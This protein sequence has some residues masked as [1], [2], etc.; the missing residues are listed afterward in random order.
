MVGRIFPSSTSLIKPSQTSFVLCGSLLPSSPNRYHGSAS[1]SR[2]RMARAKPWERGTYITKYCN[3]LEQNSIGPYI[4]NA[5][6]PGCESYHNQSSPILQALDPT[7][8]SPNPIIHN[9]HPLST[10]SR[11][12][13]PVF[14]PLV[15]LV[16]NNIRT[17][18]INHPSFF[19][20]ANDS[21][22]LATNSL[23]NLHSHDT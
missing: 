17:D 7:L 5:P 14:P 21:N 12:P 10:V 20:S 6:I 23:C 8:H 15:S 3:S 9:I 4:F 13:N 2:N 19:R 22:D 16:H 18:P 11:L 1:H